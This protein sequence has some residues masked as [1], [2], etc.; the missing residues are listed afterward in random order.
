MELALGVDRGKVCLAEETARSKAL[1][2]ER[3]QQVGGTKE[4]GCG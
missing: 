4:D 3:V 1:R 2:W